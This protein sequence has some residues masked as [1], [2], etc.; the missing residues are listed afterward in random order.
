MVCD[1]S[2]A[3]SMARSTMPGC[4]V[5]SVSMFTLPMLSMFLRPMA[6]ARYV[7]VRCAMRLS[8]LAIRARSFCTAVKDLWPSGDRRR[9]ER[10][11]DGLALENAA[12][13]ILFLGLLRL[14]DVE[15]AT[16]RIVPVK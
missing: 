3:V 1:T 15:Q 8:P 12:T 6:F 4:S 9:V 16:Q 5:G 7:T 2:V 11:G 13:R 14:E 10:R